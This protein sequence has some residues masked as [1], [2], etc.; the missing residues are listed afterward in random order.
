MII[1]SCSGTKIMATYSSNNC[2][3]W[4]NVQ[5]KWIGFYSQ[6]WSSILS[7]I[8]LMNLLFKSW[9]LSLLLRLV[10]NSNLHSCMHNDHWIFMIT[11]LYLVRLKFHGRNDT[12]KTFTSEFMITKSE[13]HNYFACEFT[14]YC[15]HRNAEMKTTTTNRFSF[16]IINS[17]T[18]SPGDTLDMTWL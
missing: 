17:L 13:L 5:L 1:V 6:A 4:F 7:R 15:A 16:W 8:P 2:W 14:A 10:S 9:I 18:E 3:Y 12:L 11:S